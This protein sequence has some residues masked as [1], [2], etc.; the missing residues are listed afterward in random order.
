LYLRLF[1]I[2]GARLDANMNVEAGALYSVDG[3][4]S[5]V[6]IGPS[7]LGQLKRTSMVDAFELDLGGKVGPIPRGRYALEI[8][9]TLT[10]KNTSKALLAGV[11]K[12]KIPLRVVSPLKV[13]KVHIKLSDSTKTIVDSP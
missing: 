12:S 3:A 6:P 9:A 10:Q 8:T 1:D 7:S 4:G 2:F 5:T 13:D 11:V